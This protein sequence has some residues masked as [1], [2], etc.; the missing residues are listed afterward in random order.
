[1][2]GTGDPVPEPACDDF[3]PAPWAGIF[4][5]ETPALRARTISGPE[6]SDGIGGGSHRRLQTAPVWS[7]GPSSSPLPAAGCASSQ[8]MTAWVSSATPWPDSAEMQNTGPS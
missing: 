1:M 3:P 4:L 8:A 6:R 5:P 7:R 2:P